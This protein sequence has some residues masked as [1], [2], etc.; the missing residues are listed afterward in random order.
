AKPFHFDLAKV[1][2]QQSPFDGRHDYRDLRLS[3]RPLRAGRARLLSSLRSPGHGAVA[4]TDPRSDPPA[5]GRNALRR[6]RSADSRTE[7]RVPGSVHR[8]T[9]TRIRP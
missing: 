7:G 2:G 8:L 5:A 6:T 3:A 9:E 1:V 4:R